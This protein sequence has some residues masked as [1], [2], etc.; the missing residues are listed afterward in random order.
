MRYQRGFTL[1]ELML[2]MGIFLMIFTVMTQSFLFLSQSIG[3]IQDAQKLSAHISSISQVLGTDIDEYLIDP[4]KSST[5]A[6]TLYHPVSGDQV[7]Y[8]FVDIQGTLGL[9]R[10]SAEGVV[11]LTSDQ[12]PMVTGGFEVFPRATD[13]KKCLVHP[14]VRIHIKF[15]NTSLLQT[16]FSSPHS[17]SLYQEQC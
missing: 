16:S 13:P 8:S 11:A 12:Y 3:E 1:V 4:V 14:F 2:S 7:T 15:E 6:L 10:S 17:S 5:T 9:Q